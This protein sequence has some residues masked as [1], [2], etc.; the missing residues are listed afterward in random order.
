ML[1]KKNHKLIQERQADRAQRFGLRKLGIG[2]V[3]V[4]LGSVM[5]ITTSQNKVHAASENSPETSVISG[6]SNS[7][8]TASDSNA[9]SAADTSS[10]ATAESTSSNKSSNAADNQVAATSRTATNTTS[11]TDSTSDQSTTAASST[12]S[13]QPVNNSEDSNDNTNSDSSN[14]VSSDK[15]TTVSTDKLSTNSLA[16]NTISDSKVATTSASSSSTTTATGTTTSLGYVVP[17]D[18][19]N[20]NTTPLTVKDKYGNTLTLNK[21]TVGTDTTGLTLEYT[22]NVKNGDSVTIN[23]PKGV[24]Y[25]IVL[26]QGNQLDGG[27]LP[28][29]GIGTGTYTTDSNGN[30][31]VTYN[32]T[33]A[34]SVQLMLNFTAKNSY[35][36]Q[37]SPMDDP[38]GTIAK[39]ITWT[40][41][42]DGVTTNNPDLILWQTLANPDITID[43][44]SRIVPSETVVKR[45]LPN[46]EYTFSIKASQLDGLPLNYPGT[47][48]SRYVNN[49][50]TITVPV[51]EDFVLNAES[52]LALTQLQSK[53]STSTT[54]FS[55]VTITQP[56][57]KGHDVIITVPKG[58]GGTG[59]DPGTTFKLVGSFELDRPESD[60]TLSSTTNPL[61]SNNG[62]I[63]IQEQIKTPD[64]LKTLTASAGT[65]TAIIAGSVP[66]DTEGNF[67]LVAY[68]NNQ[69]NTF[70]LDSD[71]NDDPAI[72]NYF[73]FS[74][75]T[76]YQ[77]D[78]TTITLNLADGL[79]VTAI[80][81]PVSSTTLPGTTEYGYKIYYTDGTT[82]TGSVAAG[83]TVTAQDGK[84][85]RKID[86]MPNVIKSGSATNISGIPYSQG[87]YGPTKQPDNVVN[88]IAYGKLGTTKDDGTPIVAGDELVS[89]ITINSADFDSSK[90]TG[91]TNTQTVIGEDSLV[92]NGQTYTWQGN[93]T[94]GTKNAGYVGFMGGLDDVNKNS[95]RVY[96]PIIYYVLPKYFTYNYNLNDLR[97][98]S[99]EPKVTSYGY[100][101]RQVVKIDYT[102]TGQYIN[103]ANNSGVYD[104]AWLDIS[105]DALPGTYQ[106][107]VYIYSPHT[108]LL[109]TVATDIDRDIVDG[110]E[111][112]IY[113]AG[114]GSYVV[115]VPKIYYVPNVSQGNL[116]I[117]QVSDG[118]SSDKGSDKMQY[119]VSVANYT[120]SAMNNAHLLIN[121]PQADATHFQF[122]LTGP[123]SFEQNG[124]VTADDITLYYSIN[125]QDFTGTERGDQV[126]MDGYVTADQVTDWSAIK[127]VIAV[128]PKVNASTQIGRFVL[129]GVDK[130]VAED[131]G[132]TGSLASTLTSDG[133]I[134][135]T[136]DVTKI[137]VIGNSTVTA[138]YHY[139]DAKGKDQY[140][141][142]PDLT[143]EYTDNKSVMN[144]SDF[145]LTTADKALI[146]T[147]Y[148]L[149]TA[150]PTIVA[151]AKTW[152]TDAP[153]GTAAFGQTVKYYFDGD[154]VQYE[155][156]PKTSDESKTITKTINYY[157]NV[158]GEEVKAA[159]SFTKSVTITKSTNLVTNNVV[160]KVDNKEL[161]DGTTTLAGQSLPTITGY[162]Y[163]SA[164]DA[165]DDKTNRLS[166]A[167]GNT[168]VNYDSTNLVINVYYVAK[169]ETAN[170]KFIDNTTGDTLETS[171][172]NGKF[173]TDI[174]F[175]SKEGN[176]DSVA[177]II[178]HYESL[179]YVLVHK[180]ASDTYTEYVPGNQYTYKE[181]DNSFEVHFKHGTKEASDS[182]VINETI[183]YVYEDGK[184]AHDDV[185]AEKSFTRTGETD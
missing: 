9:S 84:Y 17:S 69:S 3:S 141:D 35:Y 181:G 177:D 162:K 148:E 140:I 49:G 129:T 163:E 185:T 125:T 167:T 132:K 157:K 107:E 150:A 120:T 85:I 130:N 68:G 72:V 164:V 83:D 98:K 42:R 33:A 146:P 171:S 175:A 21:N 47:A 155:L 76:A 93:T 18:T 11:T 32:F 127:S 37:N 160:Y 179:G 62:K 16:T 15:S 54:N 103:T 158:N 5:T 133:M 81:T 122:Q 73:G 19:Y 182:K 147:N 30:D 60:V 108:K 45:V 53:N 115:S 75:N 131:A 104:Q 123:I 36:A 20:A 169:D 153:D 82:A 57:G 59:S 7:A 56:G 161:S 67:G 74:N 102:G 165:S 23:I 137:S 12:A 89:S 71:P 142:L 97:N 96:E 138:R 114:T 139:V 159:D 86:F 109:N 106:A 14:N 144:Q 24:S 135:F 63:L 113:N 26:S 118:T 128:F 80:K 156:V 183:H 46:A 105:S 101:G 88:F 184:P 38:I 25:Q 43:N 27:S 41:T 119:Y 29:A 34:S 91:T 170:I 110:Q 90:T 79:D 65:W 64:G 174:T 6:N 58:N 111:G 10:N 154:I 100:D 95:Q 44:V 70:L 116:D 173:G 40:S 121:L 55:G 28:S 22:G 117:S 178:S 112:T 180:G 124:P 176:G 92:S 1:S 143:K 4:I 2:L 52:S 134:P 77:L 172:N 126:S 149:S 151:G 48:L 152:T 94:P 145:A 166:D 51:P 66:P 61:A 136:S 13:S 39:M 31:I 99:G 168:I 8:S 87:T 78:D 50:A